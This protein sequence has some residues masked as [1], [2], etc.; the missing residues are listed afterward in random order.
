MA[1]VMGI[2]LPAGWEIIYNKTLR[3][4]DISVLCNVGKNPRW[5]PR[6]RFVTL[7]EVTYLYNIAYIWGALTADEKSEWNYASNVIGQHNYNLFVQDKSYRIKHGIP[8]NAT[9]SLY[10]QYLV[11][12]I[13][14][15]SPAISAKIIQ[16]NY[17][18]IIF[19]CFFEICTKTNL[20]SAGADPYCR[21]ILKWFRYT[22]GQTFEEVETID[23]PL[24]QGWNKAKKWVSDIA[25]RKGKWQ[26]EL[27]LND[28]TGEF[29]FDNPGV[30][31]SGEQK[32]NDPTCED[33]VNWWKGD[34][35]GDGVIFNTV[36]PPD[37]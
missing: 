9:P 30:E 37:S 34:N 21:F 13:N 27:V 2:T 33:V 15:A 36:Y 5:F 22:T 16:F 11:G 20:V 23:I 6:K 8:G 12:H 10:H 25:G 14:I 26:V 19:P 1:R 18:K 24:V 28:V 3:M 29:W 7:K 32:L 17:K 31:Y 4:Y 35:I